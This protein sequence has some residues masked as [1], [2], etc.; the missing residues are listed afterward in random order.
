MEGA[1]NLSRPVF[2][3][4]CPPADHP[5]EDQGERRLLLRARQEIKVSF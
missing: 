4:E 2:E 5:H 1:L 3:Q